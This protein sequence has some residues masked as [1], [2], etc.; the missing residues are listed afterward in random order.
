VA[1]AAS[2][3]AIVNGITAR[4]RGKFL[5]DLLPRPDFS[6]EIDGRPTRVRLSPTRVI[7]PAGGFVIQ[8]GVELD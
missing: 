5:R 1:L 2:I 8:G 6:F 3:T 7:A 4:Y